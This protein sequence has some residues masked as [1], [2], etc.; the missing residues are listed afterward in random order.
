MTRSRQ[1]SPR[2]NR[3]AWIGEEQ[4]PLPV[5]IA[6]SFLGNPGASPA[7]A[8]A[9][10]DSLG[11]AAQDLAQDKLQEPVAQLARRNTSRVLSESCENGR[12]ASGAAGLRVD[13]SFA[14]RTR[15]RRA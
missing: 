5:G 13:G 4:L 8:L 12:V 2:D 3:K 11:E 7:A 14:E 6:H 10:S 15:K 9:K 1:S